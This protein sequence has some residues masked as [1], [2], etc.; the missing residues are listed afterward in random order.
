[1][2]KS[3]NN[4][5]SS[6]S[7]LTILN[8]YQDNEITI[9]AHWGT[10]IYNVI[11]NYNDKDSTGFGSTNVKNAL[12]SYNKTIS[13]GSKFEL[14]G[15]IERIGYDF[16]GWIVGNNLGTKESYNASIDNILASN[17]NILNYE[18]LARI[19]SRPGGLVDLYYSINQNDIGIENLGD[20]DDGTEHYIYL[21]AYFTPKVYT[22]KFNSNDASTENNG[23]TDA[24]YKENGR[25]ES[26]SCP[27]NGCFVTFDSNDW[28][29]L[30]A[31][32]IDRFGYSF[33]AWFNNKESSLLLNSS[34]EKTVISG[35]NYDELDINEFEKTI[36]VYAGWQATE[37]TIVYRSIGVDITEIVK[38]YKK[39]ITFDQEFDAYRPTKPGYD[40]LGWAFTSYE[41]LFKGDNSSGFADS[42]LAIVYVPTDNIKFLFGNLAY[43]YSLDAYTNAYH[44]ENDSGIRHYDCDALDNRNKN[45]IVYNGNYYLYNNPDCTSTEILGET[46]PCYVT[47]YAVWK[48][49][50][51]DIVFDLNDSASSN[52]YKVGSTKAY[53]TANGWA[54]YY[55]SYEKGIQDGLAKLRITIGSPYTL[56]SYDKNKSSSTIGAD[57]YGYTWLGWYFNADTTKNANS[58]FYKFISPYQTS[59]VTLT[60]QMVEK[61]IEDGIMGVDDTELRLYA[62]WQANTYTIDLLGNAV[63]GSTGIKTVSKDEYRDGVRYITT[64][65]DPVSV[66]FDSSVS[67][68]FYRIGYNF[69]GYSFIN[70][71]KNNTLERRYTTGDSYFNNDAVMRDGVCYLYTTSIHGAYSESG[72]LEKFGDGFDTSTDDWHEDHYVVLYVGWKAIEYTINISLNT[73]LPNGT[74]M[75]NFGSRDSGYTLTLDNVATPFRLDNDTVLAYTSFKSININFKLAFDSY[76]DDAVTVYQ[77]SYY[78]L[79]DLLISLTGYRFNSLNTHYDSQNALNTKVV[80][81]GITQSDVLLNGTLFTKLY[82][83]KVT[84]GTNTIPDVQINRLSDSIAEGSQSIVITNPYGDNVNDLNSFTLF[85]GYDINIYDITANNSDNAVGGISGVYELVN[86]QNSTKNFT[87]PAVQRVE[88]GLTENVVAIPITSGYFTS[89]ATLKFINPSDGKNYKL[90]LIL[91]F[92]SAKR[93][94]EI[95]NFELYVYNASKQNYELAASGVADSLK[96][97]IIYNDDN[98]RTQT[99]SKDSESTTLAMDYIFSSLKIINSEYTANTITLCGQ[100]V[101]FDQKKDDTYYSILVLDS[102]KTDI[103][104]SFEYAIQQFTTTV[105]ITISDGTSTNNFK[106]TEV[107]D[108]GTKVID[109]T[110]TWDRKLNATSFIQLGWY[111]YYMEGSNRI[112]EEISDRD[113]VI[114]NDTHLCC[115]YKPDDNTNSK[116]VVFYNWDETNDHYKEYDGNSNYILQGISYEFDPN[117][118]NALNP[119][120]IGYIYDNGTWKWSSDADDRSQ[121]FGDFKTDGDVLKYAKLKNVPSIGSWY[122]GSQFICYVAFTDED[123]KNLCNTY[124]L[125]DEDGNLKYQYMS[126][127]TEQNV[128]M[129]VTNYYT[130]GGKNYVDIIFE[131]TGELATIDNGA[132]ARIS[133]LNV[134]ST[135]TEISGNIYA[136]QAYATLEF[137]IDKDDNFFNITDSNT[138]DVAAKDYAET[139]T[140]FEV[141]NNNVSYYSKS[142]IDIM[143][144]VLNSLQYESYMYSRSLNTTPATALYSVINTFGLTPTAISIND[145]SVSVPFA[146]GNYV[147]L[148]YYKYDSKQG[149]VNKSTIITVCDIYLANNAGA[150]EYY[151]IT[152]NVSFSE[153]SVESSMDIEGNTLVRVNKSLMNTSYTD[154]NENVYTSENLKFIMFTEAQINEYFELF[155]SLNSKEK[156]LLQMITD[157]KYLS[158]SDDS[159]FNVSQNIYI[160]GFYCES[161]DG[162]IT[163]IVKATSNYIYVIN[164]SNSHK[165][166]YIRDLMFSESTAEN[167]NV[168]VGETMFSFEIDTNSMFTTKYDYKTNTEYNINSAEFKL[169]FIAFNGTEFKNYTDDIMNGLYTD[170]EALAKAI[171][172]S[173]YTSITST[174]YNLTRLSLST[175]DTTAKSYIIAFYTDSSNNV[176]V[177]SANI[178]EISYNKDTGILT[179][180]VNTLTN[181][182]SFTLASMNITGSGSTRTVTINRDYFNSNYYDYSSNTLIAST[183]YKFIYLSDAE[184]NAFKDFYTN[185]AT[186]LYGTQSKTYTNLTLE[187][188]LML[189]IY[190][191]RNIGNNAIN[192]LLDR[193]TRDSG[194]VKEIISNIQSVIIPTYLTSYTIDATTDTTTRDDNGNYSHNLIAYAIGTDGKVIDKIS[195]NFVNITYRKDNSNNITEFETSIKSIGSLVK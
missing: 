27:I 43:N 116:K 8:E 139:V 105:L 55:E 45:L 182:I 112:L 15:N 166:I 141:E 124:N 133:K 191:Y 121:F 137:T 106:S 108:Y 31:V 177:V 41:I 29:S 184:I 38:S 72:I 111:Y 46:S 178:L 77:G 94:T 164:S 18:Y 69:L 86:E 42:N 161:N 58:D 115:A 132:P 81:E 35:E 176:R 187:E 2:F 53:I 123:I 140:F 131:G 6:V 56:L 91:K 11:I 154:A 82:Y 109:I 181:D 152:N 73:V 93:I 87:A 20:A 79:D 114:N 149:T 84:Y 64:T 34:G 44:D 76:F 135:S 130:E 70:Y 147:F 7:Q 170:I 37:Y 163:R 28:V 47:L 54:S 65:M 32:Y 71:T 68:S 179:S 156:A 110:T 144:V 193:L 138:L 97:Y 48:P 85:A 151:P 122:P 143:M 188:S 12:E 101:T 67:F 59:K 51:F 95:S 158:I 75:R 157:N 92:N 19:T 162:G 186:I 24:F 175:A 194:T 127:I 119:S 142:N 30:D 118:G 40:F 17:N 25:Y 125:R 33:R 165:I 62:G 23:S 185:G 63:G 190:Y 52:T 189:T 26:K 14:I 3:I 83:E 89:K 96:S 5:S 90:D 39:T 66:V 159:S 173:A 145:S 9:Y 150:L 128:Y 4:I 148:F 78:K 36:T 57:R 146:D 13:L 16:I 49:K 50:T 113:V 80:I 103:D 102:I 155:A 1:M 153:R 61:L 107:H 171:A 174:D 126:Q 160:L 21:Y 104:I 183:S 172:N 98:G 22:V 10:N 100:T 60:L 74:T 88:F 180:R 129:K 192:T 117:S 120:Y 99:I 134:L 195:S 136:L 167:S 168:V 169:R